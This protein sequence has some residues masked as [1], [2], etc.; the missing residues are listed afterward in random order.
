MVLEQQVQALGEFLRS[1]AGYG[2]WPPSQYSYLFVMSLNPA[3]VRMMGP[4]QTLLLIMGILLSALNHRAILP[5]SLI[6]LLTLDYSK[7]GKAEMRLGYIFFC[8]TLAIFVLFG[9]WYHA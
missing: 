8:L 5:F 4:A 7:L 1:R 2:I 6:I 3:F 9:G